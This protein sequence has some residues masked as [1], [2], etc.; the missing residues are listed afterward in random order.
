VELEFV[1]QKFG[2]RRLKDLAGF[3]TDSTGIVIWRI[4]V[5]KHGRKS[6]ALK[7]KKTLENIT[8]PKVSLIPKQVGEKWR[9]RELNPGLGVLQRRH[10]RV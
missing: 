7:N 6:R 5:D 4:L 2:W 8:F 9:R 10:L 3:A 1:I